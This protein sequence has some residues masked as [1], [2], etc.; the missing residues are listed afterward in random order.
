MAIEDKVINEWKSR[1]FYKPESIFVRTTED[2]EEV[3]AIVTPNIARWRWTVL[4]DCLEVA[5]GEEQSSELA[6][7]KADL[8]LSELV[9]DL[10]NIKDIFSIDRKHHD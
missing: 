10:S 8:T 3:V 5:A 1:D 2:K 7:F 4:S 9:T 6:R